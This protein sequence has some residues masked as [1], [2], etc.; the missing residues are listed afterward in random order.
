[1]SPCFLK[2]CLMRFAVE[3]VSANGAA[4][5]L[6]DR[7]NAYSTRVMVAVGYLSS[8]HLSEIV[9]TDGTSFFFLS[10]C[11]SPPRMESVGWSLLSSLRWHGCFS[12]DNQFP[13]SSYILDY[14]VLSGG[15]IRL[16]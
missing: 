6:Y 2:C 8:I 14:G 13:F 9:Q 1:M 12:G 3:D 16:H 5:C 7:T 10:C 15:N 4:P 11:G